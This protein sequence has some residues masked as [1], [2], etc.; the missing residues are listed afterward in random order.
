MS[1]LLRNWK[2]YQTVKIISNT[3]THRNVKHRCFPS[4][5]LTMLES[6]LNGEKKT[7][8][9][10]VKEFIFIHIRELMIL[11]ILPLL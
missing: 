6:L 7:Q 8:N 10:G 9:M 1:E 2:F 4:Q 11:Q 5:P 3:L